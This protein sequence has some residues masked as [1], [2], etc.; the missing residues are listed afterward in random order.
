MKKNILLNISLVLLSAAF[1]AGCTTKQDDAPKSK[2]TQKAETSSSEEKEPI[3]VATN[4]T[5]APASYKDDDGN[6]TGFEYD[7]ME[8]IGKRCGRKIEWLEIE[9]LDNLFGNLD[10]GKADT[11]AFQI[12]INE[13]R[14]ANYTFS[15]VYGNNKIFLCVREDFKYDT[16]DDL[17][18][19]IVSLNPTHSMYPLLEEYNASLPD[20]KKIQIAS[21]ESSSMYD[22]LELGRIDAFPLTEVAFQT[23]MEK[24]DYKIK[25]DGEALVIE[26]NAYPFAKDADSELI[27]DVNEALRSMREDGTLT[28]IS[29]KHYKVDVTQK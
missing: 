22:D 10:A 6:L 11:I 19:K 9:G 14:K 8:E 24:Q 13:E 17:Q 15:D 23:V 20:D 28:E 5:F 21:A 4:P 26:E 16:L 25:L 1:I 29:M 27:K 12:S 3:R 18:G 2:T 7:T